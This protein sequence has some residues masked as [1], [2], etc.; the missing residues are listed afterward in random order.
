MRM[1]AAALRRRAAGGGR[2]RA[3]EGALLEAADLHADGARVVHHRRLGDLL[4]VVHLERARAR[5]VTAIFGTVGPALG[6]R[7]LGQAAAVRAPSAQTIVNAAPDAG[8]R[9]VE[10]LREALVVA[11]DHNS[12]EST[13]EEIAVTATQ[14][15]TALQ[16][17][18]HLL[19]R[20]GDRVRLRGRRPAIL[21]GGPSERRSGGNGRFIFVR[22]AGCMA[23]A[24]I[25][26]A[27]RRR[28][29]AASERGRRRSGSVQQRR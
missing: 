8:V 26:C 7:A 19:L 21:E 2:P 14:L 25:K 29:C 18:K 20:A 24:E 15:F 1:H 28:V 9:E 12:G 11:G 10:A 4:H 5:A 6:A 22:R 27:A 16:A 23:S 17:A 13:A 3:R